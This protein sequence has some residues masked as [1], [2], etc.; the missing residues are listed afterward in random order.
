MLKTNRVRLK[1]CR[2][3]VAR[4]G[5]LPR[6]QRIGVRVSRKQKPRDSKNPATA[7]TPE[8]TPMGRILT[9]PP[10]LA[11]RCRQNQRAGG[12]R[13]FTRIESHPDANGD[14]PHYVRGMLVRG[15]S[16]KTVG[17]DVSLH[18]PWVPEV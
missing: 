5:P 10:K 2:K 1:G 13:D 11:A 4:S 16:F 12:V 9:L 15:G 17:D 14:H 3:H 18:I 6:P 7:K 8:P